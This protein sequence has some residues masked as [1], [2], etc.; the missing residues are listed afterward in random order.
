MVLD[1]RMFEPYNTLGIDVICSALSIY[2]D[3]KR[4]NG[5]EN[6]YVENYFRVWIPDKHSV[7][8]LP[9][10]PSLRTE[11]FPGRRLVE[12]KLV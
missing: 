10:C 12:V 6:E 5:K 9:S 7:L 11:P 4:V 3:F 1:L 2:S 8:P